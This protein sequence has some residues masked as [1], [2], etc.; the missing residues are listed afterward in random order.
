MEY[1]CPL[2]LYQS[3]QLGGGLADDKKIIVRHS[4]GRLD[5]DDTAGA[6]PAAPKVMTPEQLRQVKLKG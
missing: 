1:S 2:L 4:G 3:D 5:D 6:S